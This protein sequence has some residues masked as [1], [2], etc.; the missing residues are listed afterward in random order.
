M[1]GQEL[2]L[3]LSVFVASLVEC[4]EA[5]TIVLAVGST[6]SWTSALGGAGVAAAV[7]AAL[8]AVLGPALTGLPLSTLRLVVGGLLL[9]FGLQWLQKAILRAAGLKSIREFAEEASAA[10]AAGMVRE[11]FDGY[12][13][14]IA[15]KGV[16]LE[17]LE[18]VF[19]VLTFGANQ[20][21]I[22]LA[23][24]AAI[25]AAFSVMVAGLLVHRPLARV[26]ENAMK[27]AVGVMLTSFGTFWGAEGAGAT[28]PGGDAALLAVVPFVFLVSLGLATGARR[29]VPPTE[30]RSGPVEITVVP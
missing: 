24:A 26:P 18:V 22:G 14:I 10:A 21:R 15:T 23:A 12:S 19:I 16:L 11:G 2:G 13:F 25:L 4:I 28:W 7:L 1:S 27:F 20:H 8:T 3:A 5:L 9:I 30:A 17:G 29:L 6:R